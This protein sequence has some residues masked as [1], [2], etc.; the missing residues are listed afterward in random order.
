ML[1]QQKNHIFLWRRALWD[2]IKIKL[3]LWAKS[4]RTRVQVRG[5]RM[6]ALNT[7]FTRTSITQMDSNE[8]IHLYI[9]NFNFFLID[10]Q[11][12]NVQWYNPQW[13]NKAIHNIYQTFTNNHSPRDSSALFDC[14]LFEF[15]L[16]R[17]S[18]RCYV[19]LQWATN[20]KY[21]QLLKKV[22][23]EIK[24]QLQF[25]FPLKQLLRAIFI[26]NLA[27]SDVNFYIWKYI[28]EHCEY[29][30]EYWKYSK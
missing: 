24:I 13:L 15:A 3:F 9:W 22:R 10:M 25:I 27:W 11:L 8:K 17:P 4:E 28:H 6:G 29:Y 12:N 30:I 5:T 18:P 1:D 7:Y 14:I 2:A 23:R 16:Y 20:S 19:R 26:S 21:W